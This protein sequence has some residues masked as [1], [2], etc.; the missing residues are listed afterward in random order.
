MKA[1]GLIFKSKP[2]SFNKATNSLYF[3]QKKAK[4]KFRFF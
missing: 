4:P 1:Y 2:D 3:R